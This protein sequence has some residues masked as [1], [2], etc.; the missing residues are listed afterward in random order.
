MEESFMISDYREDDGMDPGLGEMSY[1]GAEYE[2]D[3]F[4]ER[5]GSEDDIYEDTAAVDEPQLESADDG[6][7][8]E[9]QTRVENGFNETLKPEH[10]PAINEQLEDPELNRAADSDYEAESAKPDQSSEEDR[11]LL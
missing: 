9:P 8:M 3:E 2:M 10:D 4:G 11:P 5:I 1:D 7:N 6:S